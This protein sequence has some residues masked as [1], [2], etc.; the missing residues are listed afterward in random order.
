MATRIKSKSIDLV[1]KHYNEKIKV[2][3]KSKSHNLFDNKLF[4]A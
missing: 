1:E 4:S 3:N 2:W